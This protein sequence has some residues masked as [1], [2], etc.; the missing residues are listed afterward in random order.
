MIK[1]LFGI[2]MLA[3]LSMA[4]GSGN[5]DTN[6][7]IKAIYIY[8]FTKYIEW[9]KEYRET[10]FV[11]GVL[12]DSPLYT[13]LEKMSSSKQVFGQS[14]EVKK[15][16]SASDLQKCHIL[17]IPAGSTATFSSVVSKVQS[18]STLLVTDTPG[19]AKK[20]SAINFVVM[21]NRQKF[22][23]NQANAVKYNLKVS[24][25]LE[26]LAILVN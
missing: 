6:A 18:N 3:V 7:K 13:E 1:R 17:Y 2:V 12:G 10:S 15:F 9:P 24:N 26:A 20:G 14:I 23:L 16:A 21:Q 22:E 4:T 5:Y 19:M 11:I 8:N 25:S